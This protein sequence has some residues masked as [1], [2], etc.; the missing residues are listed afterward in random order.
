MAIV[1]ISTNRMNSAL[2]G[3]ALALAAGTAATC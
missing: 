3:T 1:T 2:N